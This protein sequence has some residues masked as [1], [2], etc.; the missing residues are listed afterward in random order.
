MAHADFCDSS[1]NP[2]YSDSGSHS[3]HYD[4]CYDFS[5]YADAWSNCGAHSN[6]SPTLCPGS[7]EGNFYIDNDCYNDINFSHTPHSNV[8]F[9]HTPHSNVSFYNIPFSNIA[10]SH[11]PFSNIAFSHTSH[12]DSCSH[13]DSN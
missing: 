13:S 11:T 12:Y 6:D 10:F 5:N 7:F 4:T 3:D 1:Y 2:G 8:A 9:S